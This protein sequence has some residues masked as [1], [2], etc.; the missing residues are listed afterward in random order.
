MKRMRASRL[1]LVVL[2]LLV[3]LLAIPGVVSAG[4]WA[5]VTL[6]QLPQ[7]LTAGAA[8]PLGFMVRQH[9]RTPF[10][11][12]QIKI[13]AQHQTSGQRLTFTALPDETPGHYRVDLLFPQGGEWAWG[14]KSG[15]YPDVQP[16]PVL[17]VAEAGS[18]TPAAAP[19]PAIPMGILGMGALFGLALGAFIFVRRQVGLLAGA[20]AAGVLVLAGVFAYRLLAVSA[21]ASIP[22]NAAQGAGSIPVTGDLSETGQRLFVAK[23]CVVC[24]VND[25]ALEGAREI[26]VEV[27]PNLTRFPA[28]P[29]YLS[30]FLESPATAKPGT[31]MPDLGLSADEIEAL[32]AF[33]SA[34]K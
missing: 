8:Y 11:V 6:D 18:G 12:E 21:A 19:K 23:G 15:L 24:H 31:E 34:S 14:V 33:L 16:L 5:V 27:G 3:A 26:S 30:R 32:T 29:A 1:F 22:A 25:R 13:E 28:D 17:Q 2:L 7:G 20:L 9:G 10:T 4:G